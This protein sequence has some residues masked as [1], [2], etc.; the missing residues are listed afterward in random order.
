MT[1][2]DRSICVPS[3]RKEISTGAADILKILSYAEIVGI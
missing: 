2:S 3:M 1:G